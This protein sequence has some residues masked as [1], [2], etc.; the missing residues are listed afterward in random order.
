[1]I[2]IQV[3]LHPPV[4]SDRGGQIERV[5]RPLDQRLIAQRGMIA[6]KV[7]RR[8]QAIR[9]ILKIVG[10]GG[11]AFR[12]QRVGLR[13][14]ESHAIVVHLFH[15]AQ[16]GPA[17]EHAG[18]RNLEVFHLVLVPVDEIVGRERLAV[19]PAHA[20]PQPEGEN[21]AVRRR[22]PGLREVGHQR[23]AERRPAHQAR[24]G[25][26]PLDD[27][28]V[29][30]GIGQPLPGA[31]VPADPIHAQHHHRLRTHP[32]R[33]RRQFPLPHK[34]AQDWRLVFGPPLRA[35]P[36]R[37]VH[38]LG[39]AYARL[40]R[41]RL[42]MPPRLLR[43]RRVCGRRW[44]RRGGHIRPEQRPQAVEHRRHGHQGGAEPHER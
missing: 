17:A 8:R 26:P 1:M 30:V 3:V 18:R 13:K 31:A 35:R 41:Q 32:L 15:P 25:E 5:H 36:F 22:L 28:D 40:P 14:A 44:R 39:D 16:A 9:E 2:R 38:L 23:L 20:A 29:V 42:R 37:V 6:A 34:F 24:I 10:L 27:V 43:R 21:A 4:D 11:D 7:V 12:E 19:R 33:Q